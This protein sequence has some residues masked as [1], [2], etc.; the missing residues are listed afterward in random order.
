MAVCVGF[1]GCTNEPKPTT[2]EYQIKKEEPKKVVKKTTKKTTKKVV[3]KVETEPK[4]TELMPEIEEKEA[5]KTKNSDETYKY[6]VIL[7]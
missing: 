6:T 5:P 3:Q 7:D 4:T 2:Q 1:I